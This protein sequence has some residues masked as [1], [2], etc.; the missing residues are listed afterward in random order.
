MTAEEENWKIRAAC[1]GM[2]PESDAIFF[3]VSKNERHHEAIAAAVRICHRCPVE[4]DCRAWA[5]ANKIEYGVFGGLTELQRKLYLKGE[6][7]TR[8]CKQCG[9]AFL[10]GRNRDQQLYC[11]KECSKVAHQYRTM[12]SQTLR[13]DIRQDMNRLLDQIVA[14]IRRSNQ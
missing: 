10:L 14:Q 8:N 9:T 12:R 6:E 2:A 1:R 13:E 4:D 11:S 3:P 7:I 5:L